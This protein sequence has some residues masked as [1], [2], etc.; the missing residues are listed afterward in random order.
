MSQKKFASVKSN[1]KPLHEKFPNESDSG[2][3]RF[4]SVKS[5]EDITVELEIEENKTSEADISQIDSWRAWLVTL[6][7]FLIVF[8]NF[9]ITY[10]WGIYQEVYL[11]K[12]FVGQATDQAISYIGT[13]SNALMFLLGPMFIIVSQRIGFRICMMFGAVLCPLALLLASFNTHLWQLY[14]TQGIM[15]GIGFACLFFPSILLPNQWFKKHLGLATGITVS[16]SGIG[17][18]CL[19]PLIN[20]DTVG[21]SAF[22]RL[23][24]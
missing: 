10:T 17:G 9:G 12:E 20:T 14:I 11:T 4:S 16:G 24:V 1:G 3:R 13:S 21:H 8:N 6:G 15:F 22:Q 7:G 19:S 2:A 23:S 5:N 18:L